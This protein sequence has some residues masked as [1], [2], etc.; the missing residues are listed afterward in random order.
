[1]IGI[2]N[3]TKEAQSTGPHRYALMINRDVLGYFIH[4]REDGLAVC[5]EKAAEAARKSE[6]NEI[7]NM[8]IALDKIHEREKQRVKA[9]DQASGPGN[10]A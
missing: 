2:V 8:F 3:V 5:L 6:R 9:P 10:Q 7:V 4:N 1:M